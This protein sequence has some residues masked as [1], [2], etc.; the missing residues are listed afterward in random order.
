MIATA[1][2]PSL[3]PRRHRPRTRRRRPIGRPTGLALSPKSAF[4]KREVPEPGAPQRAALPG[5]IERLEAEQKALADMALGLACN[6][7]G[8][9]AALIDGNISIS[10][11]VLMATTSPEGPD[12]TATMPT[13]P[14]RLHRSKMAR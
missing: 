12:I 5:L 2:I 1:S 4:A 8:T 11:G 13:A 10:T 7:H 6:S 14:A 9:I 3:R